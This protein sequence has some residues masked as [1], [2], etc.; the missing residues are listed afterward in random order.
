MKA[1]GK[2]CGKRWN[3]SFWA[4]SPFSTIFFFFYAICILESINSHISVVICSVFEFATAIREWV[5]EVAIRTTFIHMINICWNN[6]LHLQL[7]YWCSLYPL[8]KRVVSV[9]V[10]GVRGREVERRPCNHEVQSSSPGSG[11]QLWDFS[12]AFGASTGEV[13]RK[14]NR[15]RLV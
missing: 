3:C 10:S 11:S 6:L 7:S 2:H 14:Q 5:K 12:L 8:W 13:P 9:D 4:I 15:E 1:V